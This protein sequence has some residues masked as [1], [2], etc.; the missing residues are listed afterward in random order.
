MGEAVIKRRK[1]QPGKARSIN[2]LR[3]PNEIVLQVLSFLSISDC[4]KIKEIV[5]TDSQLSKLINDS[6]YGRTMVL[7]NRRSHVLLR[8]VFHKR[9]YEEVTAERLEQLLSEKNEFVTPQTFVFSFANDIHE[10]NNI[11]ERAF[12]DKFTRLFLQYPNYFKATIK[13]EL[14]LDFNN[15]GPT[16]DNKRE[17][18]FLGMLLDSFS[19]KNN[20]TTLN[21]V[22]GQNQVSADANEIK[23]MME[24]NIRQFKS[25]ESVCLNTNKLKD[26]KNFGFPDNVTSLNLIDNMIDTLPV[27]ETWLPSK[28]KHLNLSCNDLTSL[29]QVQFPD[30][31]EFL[32]IQ[33]NSITSLS[34]IRFPQ[35][36][37]T[38]N[39]SANEIMINE[40][41]LIRFSPYL[42]TLNLL[43]NPFKR[44]LSCLVIPHSLRRIYLDATLK[45][46]T[47]DAFDNRI[48]VYY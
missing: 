17:I 29:N 45:E 1:A 46:R 24:S 39:A 30:S 40:S 37:R 25:L 28:L 2:P 47:P 23:S 13:F 20:L 42:E 9:P 33:L 48:A 4:L 44:N 43:R 31:I 3:F 5:S 41:D 22:R 15:K 10:G 27:N 11:E 26:I 12:L 38:L 36:L 14:Y 19:L 34:N 16:N 7:I 32:D 18:Q 8:N 6:I 21:V 35:N